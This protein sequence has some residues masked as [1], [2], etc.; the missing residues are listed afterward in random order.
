MGLK[1]AVTSGPVI[2]KID[3]V[4]YIGNFSTGNTGASIAE[5]LLRRGH[6][7]SYLY[8]ESAQRPWRRSLL[9]DPERDWA[10]EIDRISRVHREFH[11][12]A[13]ALSEWPFATFAEYHEAVQWVLTEWRS[14]AIVLAAAVC[15]Y[16]VEANAGKIRSDLA[17]WTLEMVK[18]PKVISLVKHWRPDVFLVGFKL[19]SRATL[20]ELVETAHQSGVANRSDITVGNTLIEG[21]FSTRDTI[22]VT[23]DREVVP[24]SAGELPVKLVQ[25]ITEKFKAKE[26]EH[27]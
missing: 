10:A 8:H 2:S 17:G 23:A 27:G 25:T 7:V 21:E 11:K 19:L 15:D 1:V 14:D 13:A 12:Y 24:V 22:L 16:G 3:D 5:E 4:R 9:V 6:T 26:S 18:Y 20:D